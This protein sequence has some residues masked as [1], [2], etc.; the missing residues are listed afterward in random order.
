MGDDVEQ[1]RLQ[2]E[3]SRQA[4]A[5]TACQSHTT[6][7]RAESNER[8][9]GAQDQAVPLPAEPSNN[10]AERTSE[11]RDR[12]ARER[13]E[14]SR[15]NGAENSE[16]GESSG[17]G[18]AFWKRDL[19]VP[20]LVTV[21]GALAIAVG[22]G[23][24]NLVTKD[25]PGL[26]VS[27]DLAPQ[28]TVT[29]T[30]DWTTGGPLKTGECP[31]HSYDSK[32]DL[33]PSPSVKASLAPEDR[34]PRMPGVISPAIVTV[35]LQSEAK[36]PII[37]TGAQVNVL[38]RQVPPIA[39]GHCVSAQDVRAFSANLDKENP[40]LVRPKNEDGDEVPGFPYKV[41]SG[42]PEVLSL[43]FVTK[44]DEVRFS[45]TINWVQA[46]KKQSTT[47]DHDGKG[48]LVTPVRRVST[49]TSASGGTAS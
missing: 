6:P 11:D 31:S 15:E 4:H 16:D 18:R 46:G 47:L 14:T 48:Y 13:Q 41:S 7:N 25:E 43:K 9:E 39:V 24:W 1:E 19:L 30:E 35:T 2:G 20:A 22:T 8:T 42:D 44:R 27:D 32:A 12:P 37:I 17:G 38:S 5:E 45:I 29:T 10:S 34:K 21:L 36:E 3:G 28:P 26:Q 49:G 33:G 23:V 40:T